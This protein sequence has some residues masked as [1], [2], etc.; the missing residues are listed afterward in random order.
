[1]LRAFPAIPMRMQLT[2]S[3]DP[4]FTQLVLN[5]KYHFL[6]EGVGVIIYPFV[7]LK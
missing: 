7:Y 1:M 2:T 5:M 6:Y 3:N 4:L